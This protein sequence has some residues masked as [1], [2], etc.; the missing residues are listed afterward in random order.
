[1]SLGL[2][3]LTTWPKPIQADRLFVE[4]K[5]GEEEMETGALLRVAGQQAHQGHDMERT[6]TEAYAAAG[7]SASTRTKA[8]RIKLAARTSTS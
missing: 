5:V 2:A 4:F 7:R 6:Q 8:R 1:M 3:R